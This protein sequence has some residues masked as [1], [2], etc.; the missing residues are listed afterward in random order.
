MLGGELK[1]ARSPLVCVERRAARRFS[2]EQELST[3]HGGTQAGWERE[4][5][6]SYQSET[7]A[8]NHV[9]KDVLKEI[10]RSNTRI[11]VGLFVA[12]LITA[13]LV[14][15]GYFWISSQQEI[16]EEIFRQEFA[17]TRQLVEGVVYETRC[18]S[19]DSVGYT[20]TWEGQS[21]QGWGSPCTARCRELAVGDTQPLLITPLVPDFNICAN[22]EKQFFRVPDPWLESPT[23]FLVGVVVVVLFRL[24]RGLWKTHRAA[25]KESARGLP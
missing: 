10:R 14:L 17:R 8:I 18:R 4:G 6:C 22:R 20:W 1:G 12:A 5:A 24:G 13:G 3:R 2:R 15:A 19:H 23:P 11:S 25:R 16:E 9:N 21:F 7:E